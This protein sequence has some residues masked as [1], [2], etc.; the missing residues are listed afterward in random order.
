MRCCAVSSTKVG[1]ITHSQ[2]K[3]ISPKYSGLLGMCETEG[4]LFKQPL[5][6]IIF[7]LLY[8]TNAKQNEI[9]QHGIN[10]DLMFYR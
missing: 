5:E 6:D 7:F 9:G 8:L 4:P 10:G 2:A 1:I 3:A